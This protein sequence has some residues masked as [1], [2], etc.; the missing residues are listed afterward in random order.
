MI[1]NRI[2]ELRWVD[3]SD[4]QDHPLNWRVHSDFQRRV[5]DALIAQLGIATALL[6]Y[7]SEQYG[8]LVLVG[9]H[10]RKDLHAGVWPVLILD[11]SDAEAETLLLGLDATAAMAEADHKTLATLLANIQPHDEI[12]STMLEDLRQG[13][14]LP[15]VHDPTDDIQESDDTPPDADSMQIVMDEDYRPAELDDSL[16]TL[17]MRLPLPT[18]SKLF[19]LLA[20]APGADQDEKMRNLLSCVDREVLAS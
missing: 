16:I 9:G 4:L 12:L 13:L 2:K 1:R 10:L 15:F 20:L 19:S 18:V 5:L 8:G 3:A 14:I 6:A 11:I 17:S 7:E